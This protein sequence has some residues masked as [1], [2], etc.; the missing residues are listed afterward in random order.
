MSEFPL[1]Q[2]TYA[3]VMSIFYFD[4]VVMFLVIVST[5][6]FFIEF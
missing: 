5:A 3:K 2:A 4:Q 1:T 6:H